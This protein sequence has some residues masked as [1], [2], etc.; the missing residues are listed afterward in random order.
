MNEE[1]PSTPEKSNVFRGGLGERSQCD[2]RT[3]DVNDVHVNVDEVSWVVRE[4]SE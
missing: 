2:G 3:R 4:Q 1:N